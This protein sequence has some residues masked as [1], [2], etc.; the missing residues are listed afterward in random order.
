MSLPLLL[1]TMLSGRPLVLGRKVMLA[2]DPLVNQPILCLS[3]SP[4]ARVSFLIQPL[5]PYLCSWFPL[6]CT[7][8]ESLK[9][10][11]QY[12]LEVSERFMSRGPSVDLLPWAK[13]PIHSGLCW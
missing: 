6:R 2:G 5:L 7:H 13:H 11:V 4:T 3:F 10:K 1:G 9:D 8:Q 12:L